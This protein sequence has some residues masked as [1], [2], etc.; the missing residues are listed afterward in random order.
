MAAKLP[1]YRTEQAP[2]VKRDD[3]DLAAWSIE[4]WRC[5]QSSVAEYVAEEAEGA[6]FEV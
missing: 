4:S 3:I 2:D 6:V 1:P 5:G